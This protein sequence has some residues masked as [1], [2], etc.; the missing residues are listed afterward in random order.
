MKNI[1]VFILFLV[2]TSAGFGQK[3][4]ILDLKPLGPIATDELQVLSERF[5][6]QVVQT[7]K[8]EGMESKELAVLD[9]AIALQL[10][11]GS[12]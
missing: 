8:S 2:V 4:A 9:Q 11:D 6:S 3:I 12:S 7:Q 1:T 5:R 10:S